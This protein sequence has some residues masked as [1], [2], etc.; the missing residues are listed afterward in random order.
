MSK[1][2]KPGCIFDG[3]KG[4][5]YNNQRVLSLALQFEW[6]P[7][8]PILSETSE[9]VQFDV[10]DAIDYLQDHYCPEGYMVGFKEDGD[11]GVYEIIEL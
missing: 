6:V 9:D 4:Y 3:A 11:F 7:K 5:E 8:K 1:E 2:L 10:E